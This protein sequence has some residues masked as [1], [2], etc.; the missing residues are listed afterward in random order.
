M[1]AV[2]EKRFHRVRIR[3]GDLVNIHTRKLFSVAFIYML[4][5]ATKGVSYKLAAPQL[6]EALAGQG[7]EH[8]LSADL[9]PAG[10]ME[11]PQKHC[12]V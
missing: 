2:W 4:G 3:V 12:L 10:P 11:L 5:Y 1:S 8:E 7:D 9:I 6:T